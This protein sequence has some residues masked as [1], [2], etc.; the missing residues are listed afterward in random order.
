M[1]RQKSKNSIVSVPVLGYFVRVISNTVRLPKLHDQLV[2]LAQSQDHT[3]NLL[4]TL[5]ETQQETSGRLEEKIS[6]LI[7][8]IKDI[9]LAQDNLQGQFSRLETSRNISPKIDSHEQL[10]DRGLFANDHIMDNFYIRLEDHFRGSEENILE[11]LKEYLPYFSNSK[12]NFNKTPVLDIG[13]GRGEFLQLLK[14]NNIPAIGL[15]INHDMVKRVKE[16]S[17][18]AVQGDALSYLQATDSQNYGAITGFHLIEHIPFNTL[19]RLFKSTHHALVSGGFVIFETPNPENLIVSSNT[20]YLDPSHLHPL[21]PALMVFALETCGF[22]NV[23]IKRLHPDTSKK[24]GTL[25]PEV[26]NLLFGPQDYAVI[27]YK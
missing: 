14:T 17:L 2:Q 23:E 8:E 20:F 4:L 12:I 9:Q 11:R 26:A 18:K 13:S 1:P 21:P 15:D 25:N 3:D 24:S 5:Q 10:T 22:R 7:K 27:G 16:K 6:Q 19:L